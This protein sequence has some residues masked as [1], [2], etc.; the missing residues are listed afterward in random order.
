MSS[1]SDSWRPQ[2][3]IEA[4]KK[5]SA[6]IQKIR[7][8]FINQGYLEVETPV[9]GAFGVTDVYLEAIPVEC[10]G[11]AYA[12]QTSPEYHMKRLL[13]AGSGPI[14]QIIRAFRD[15]ESGRWHHPE[16]SMLEW[17]RPGVNHL[18]MIQEISLFFQEILQTKPLKQFTYQE[19]FQNICDIDPLNT[20]V[21]SL[22]EVLVKHALD[23]ILDKDEPDIDQYLFLIMSHVIE[24]ELSKYGMPIA[25]TDFPA[26]QAALARIEHGVALR[27]EVYYQGIE[28]ANG[29]YELTDADEQLKR[30]QSDLAKRREKGQ[31]ASPIDMRLIDAMRYGLPQSTGVAL[32]IDRLIALA[33]NQE[34][35]HSVIAF[36]D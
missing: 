8:F 28:L 16:F 4:L 20:S 36:R 29:F 34:S 30:F 17:Y 15:D 14:F 23:N 24:P 27:F 11:Q 21:S 33:L 19:V 31:K 18:E 25:I 32:G 22:N 12:L 3:S 26:S 9:M 35:I 2:A 6:L 10:M 13:A 5:R 7:G 1:S